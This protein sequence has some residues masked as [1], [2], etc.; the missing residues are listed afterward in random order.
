MVERYLPSTL[1]QS[2]LGYNSLAMD[3][4]GNL[5]SATSGSIYEINRASP[6]GTFP[7]TYVGSDIIEPYKVENDGNGNWTPTSGNL[8]DNVQYYIVYGAQ[9]CAPNQIVYQG[10]SCTLYVYYQPDAAGASSYR[11]TLSSAEPTI[12]LQ[13]IGVAQ[14]QPQTIT[15]PQPPSPVVNGTAPLPLN[16]T[17]SSGLPVTYAVYSGPGVVS[18][19]VLTFTGVGTVEVAALQ[20][21]NTEYS[22]AENQTVYITVTAAP[23]SYTA[24]ET[25]VGSPVSGTATVT[26]TTA[27]TLNMSLASAIKVVTQGSTGLDFVYASGATCMVNTAYIV[28]QACTINYTFNPG[29]PGLREGAVMLYDTS[30][31]LLGTSYISGIGDA[32]LGL[33]AQGTQ[34]LIG[35]WTTPRSPF[36]DAAGNFY[37]TEQSGNS[38]YKYPPWRNAGRRSGERPVGSGGSGRGW[39]RQRVLRG[40]ERYL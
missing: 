25:A 1:V 7:T 29:A 2:G 23:T 20:A 21:G 33:L 12:G 34:S 37:I 10:T 11:Y 22:V 18:N 6:S 3:G 32:P 27:G 19:G 16:A 5:Y 35:S 30:G 13:M 28:G 40:F 26:L 15:F 9:Y 17:A 24:G 4:V 31:I 8:G 38:I 14:K 39:R 36:V